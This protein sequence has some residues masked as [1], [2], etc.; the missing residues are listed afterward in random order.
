MEY[1]TIILTQCFEGENN[2]FINDEG[3]TIFN[4]DHEQDY[5]KSRIAYFVLVAK[6]N[7]SECMK[8]CPMLE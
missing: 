3:K 1:L 5:N 2:V 7:L 6:Y 8:K 4:N